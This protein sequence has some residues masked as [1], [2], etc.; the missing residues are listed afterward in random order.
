MKRLLTTLVAAAL[1]TSP[2]AAQFWGMPNWNAPKGGT[3]VTLSADVGMPSEDLGGGTA[4]GARGTVGFANLALTAG[5]SSWSPDNLD[6]YTA[7]GGNAA[8]RVIGGSL[9]PVALNIQLGAARVGAANTDPAVTRITAGGGLSASVPTP[10]FSIEPYVSLTNRWYATS[11]FS[12]ESQFG[13]TIG[14]N[15]GFGGL[16]GVHLAFDTEDY[17]PTSISTIGFGAHISL[18]PPMAL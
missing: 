16:F 4:F 9:L 10:G 12:T 6:A 18:R 2:A 5:V 1:V 8:F 11:G 7:V 14:A 15:L 13:F 3:G 17:G